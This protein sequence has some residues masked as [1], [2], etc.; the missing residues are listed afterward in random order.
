VRTDIGLPADKYRA[1]EGMCQFPLPTTSLCNSI[2]DEYEKIFS[3]QDS[4][5]DV[6]LLDDTMKAEFKAYLDQKEVRHYFRT[7]AFKAYKKQPACL[8]VVDL[9]SIQTG[10]RPEPYFYKVP[11]CEVSGY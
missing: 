9:P 7:T 1:F 3:A 2:F 4:F 11:I 6:E 5:F 10:L 8:F